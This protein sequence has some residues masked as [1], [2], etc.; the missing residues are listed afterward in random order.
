MAGST[1]YSMGTTPT[2]TEDIPS[3]FTGCHDH[4]PDLYCF[5]PDGDDV[6]A[7]PQEEDEHCHF[8]S[9]VE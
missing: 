3:E 4:G 7:S 1:E 5:S 8:H 6:E 9:G 2:A